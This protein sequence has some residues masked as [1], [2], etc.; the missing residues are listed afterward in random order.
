MSLTEICERQGCKRAVYVETDGRIHNYCGKTCAKK[1]AKENS[2]TQRLA[3]LL[4]LLNA[5]ELSRNILIKYV[6]C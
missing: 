3:K 6:L 1:V 2:S 4:T 5:L